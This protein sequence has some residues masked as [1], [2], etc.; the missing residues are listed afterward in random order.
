LDL[1]SL[2]V[3][4]LLRILGLNFPTDNKF[5]DIV[6]LCQIEKLANLAR[7]LGAEA[8]GLSDVGNSGDLF[9]A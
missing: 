8:F 3:G 1:G 6:L 7:S 5:S 9:I 4:L 2:G